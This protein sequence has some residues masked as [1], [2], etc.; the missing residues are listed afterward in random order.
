MIVTG[1]ESGRPTP[2]PQPMRR[3]SKNAQ[4]RTPINFFMLIPPE[5]DIEISTRGLFIGPQRMQSDLASD[6][7]SWRPFA[8]RS[9]S[10]AERLWHLPA[11]ASMFQQ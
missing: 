5:E 9:Y 8:T 11:R 10:S 7:S 4:F 1:C 3:H 6:P 2:P